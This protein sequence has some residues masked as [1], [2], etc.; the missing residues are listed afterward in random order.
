MS[1]P[2]RTYEMYREADGPYAISKDRAVAVGAG[3]V[4]IMSRHLRV[5]FFLENQ[6]AIE[7]VGGVRIP[8]DKNPIRLADVS[9]PGKAA[10]RMLLT[11]RKYAGATDGV[12]RFGSEYEVTKHKGEPF[13]AESRLLVALPPQED[14]P[15]NAM[16]ILAA[17]H[18]M[19]H[20]FELDHCEKTTCV[21]QP[22]AEIISEG[23]D[24]IAL[25][26]NRFCDFHNYALVG[27]TALERVAK[28]FGS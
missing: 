6:L 10:H 21:M 8:T 11:G 15:E 22:E 24:Q 5:P 12:S 3:V 17:T 2:L 16:G 20:V 14:D 26:T 7:P 27:V 13:A 1:I 19:G 9:L 23:L 4:S 28:P 18:A 25:Q